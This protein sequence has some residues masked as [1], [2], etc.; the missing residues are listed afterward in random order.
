VDPGFDLR[1]GLVASVNLGFSPYDEV[2][3]R[4]F[5]RRLFDRI[6]SLPGVQSASAAAFVPFGQGH[7]R[8]DVTID[9]YE[10]E[11]DEFMVPLRNMVDH[12]YFET[13][14]IPIVRGRGFDEREREGSKPVAL[15]NETMARR[16]WP[17]RDPIGSRIWADLGVER[18][19]IGIVKDGKYLTR[20]EEQQPYLYIPL[21]QAEYLEHLHF[22]VGTTGEPLSLI[23]PIQREVQRL[24]PTL[25]PPQIG[26]MTQYLEQSV[27]S[28]KGPAVFI[29]AF[30]LLAL[31]VAMAGV[32]GV[33]SYLVSQRT[34]EYGVRMALGA[35]NSEIVSLVLRR[36]LLTALSG[37]VLGLAGAF[38]ATRILTGF[39]YNV[40]AM[41]PTVFAAV[42]LALAA[43]AL[44]AC[45]V[46]ARSAA[47]VSPI[48]V[49]KAE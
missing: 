16:F 31:A 7:G 32:Y 44:L 35:K 6:E 47:K 2:E 28:A 41:D 19:V 20:A 49:L 11:P 14:G 5:Y 8:H 48:E 39:L 24:D 13:M 27:I 26:T 22:V 15:V 38:A 34:H 30:G 3:G 10:P 25:P 12:H 43:I 17:G 40:S 42:S 18:E 33:M 23:T 36:G 29:A 46:P 21:D 9:G 1:N 37:I 45:F 4:S